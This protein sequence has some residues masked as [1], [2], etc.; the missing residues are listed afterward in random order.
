[1]PTETSTKRIQ[2]F[3]LARGLAVFIMVF[4]NFQLVLA[5]A[6]DT[7]LLR[8]F[9]ELLHGK[10][11]ALFV[12]LAGVGISLMLASAQRQQDTQQLRVK[13]QILLRRA[14]FL[15]VFGTVFLPIWDA[16]IL[17]YYGVYIAIGTFMAV[18]ANS[19]LGVATLGL[20]L[21]YPLL[22]VGLEYEAGW[23]WHTMSYT[24]LW[25]LTGFIRNLLF[26]GFHPVIPW[27]AFI[28]AGLWL[29]RQNLSNKR[30]RWRIFLLSTAVYVGLQ[31]YS[32]YLLH[33]DWGIPTEDV[34]ALF[35]T[36]PM[37]PLPLYM[38]SAIAL[39]FSIIIACVYLAERY[40]QQAWLQVL[41]ITGQMALT[42]Y[43]A[44][45]V[46]GIVILYALFGMNT[47]S[48]WWVFSLALGFC[49]AAV[50]FSYWWQQRARR[51][52]M[53]LLM[54]RITG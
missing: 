52:P 11:A 32:Q 25:T 51:D 34:I 50:G 29:G 19:W 30:L 13:Q 10:G 8:P 21:C 43:V 42:H 37:P 3:D 16:D 27:L 35:G 24:D 38:F 22:M 1:M 41:V 5:Q 39:S 49:I 45:I 6:N 20:I 46:L 33:Q 17:H 18:V 53:S 9:F 44:H 48:L 15:F 28:F 47:L 14:A 40:Q 4:V 2:G 26:N 23:D 36:Q 12:V 31:A 7:T 54:R